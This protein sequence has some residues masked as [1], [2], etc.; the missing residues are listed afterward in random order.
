[1]SRLFL[2]SFRSLS[3]TNIHL[4]PLVNGAGH[5][6]EIRN[7]HGT[8]IWADSLRDSGETRTQKH[9]VDS[10]AIGI[11]MS[12]VQPGFPSVPSRV[13]CSLTGH[14]SKW[15]VAQTTRLHGCWSLGTEVRSS[16]FWARF[17]STFLRL[18]HFK[19]TVFFLTSEHKTD[20]DGQRREQHESRLSLR[21]RVWT[22]HPFRRLKRSRQQQEN[23]LF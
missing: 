22:I 21:M 14:S 3:L 13:K 10:E 5:S 7:A 2:F 11:S 12:A 1:M 20:T 8:H 18:L 15:K 6:E 4:I 19:C 23:R 16:L 17:Y 9:S